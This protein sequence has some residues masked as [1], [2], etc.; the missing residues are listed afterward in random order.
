MSEVVRRSI[1][2]DAAIEHVYGQWT[3]FGEFPR[4]LEYDAVLPMPGGRLRWVTTVEGTRREW[5]AKI[6]QMRENSRIAWVAQGGCHEAGVVSFE[7]LSPGRTRVTL[8]LRYAPDGIAHPFDERPAA[9]AARLEAGL[10]R[11]KGFMEAHGERSPRQLPSV[12]TPMH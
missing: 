8:E 7:R 4:F 9:V 3:R 12:L 2:V 1:V 11:F 5:E 6:T 10:E